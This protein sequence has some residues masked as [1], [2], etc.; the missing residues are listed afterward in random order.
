MI[1]TPSIVARTRWLRR[2]D[3]GAALAGRARA[4]VAGAGGTGDPAAAGACAEATALPLATLGGCA[5][6]TSSSGGRPRS[7]V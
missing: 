6:S 2:G 5:V 7:S 4:A 1:P 3:F